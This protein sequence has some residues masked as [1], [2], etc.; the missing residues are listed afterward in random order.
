MVHCIAVCILQSL[1]AANLRASWVSVCWI[2]ITVKFLWQQHEMPWEQFYS[3]LW[4]E[5]HDWLY[6]RPWRE[7]LVCSIMGC[8]TAWKWLHS[9]NSVFRY[10]YQQ[11]NWLVLP[12]SLLYWQRI[13]S[14]KRH[15]LSNMDLYHLLVFIVYFTFLSFT[16]KIMQTWCSFIA[17]WFSVQMVGTIFPTN[18]RKNASINLKHNSSVFMRFSYNVRWFVINQ[19]KPAKPLLWSL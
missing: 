12:V 11:V 17:N 19:Q 10:A 15:H 6:T 7:R 14:T 16:T 8:D 18:G 13:F 5:R 9:V 4:Q 2:T 1:F 3:R